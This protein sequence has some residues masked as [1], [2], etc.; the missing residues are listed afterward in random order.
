MDLLNEFQNNEY[1]R[2]AV[3]KFFYEELD[4][5][6]LDMAFKGEDV[7]AVAQ[8]KLVI[9][10]SFLELEERYTKKK[11]VDKINEAR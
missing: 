2:E 11:V 7:T 6:I 8:A 3:K 1:T 9:E 4:K 5:K 10:D